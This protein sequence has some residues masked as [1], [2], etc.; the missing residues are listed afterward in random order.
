MKKIHRNFSNLIIIQLFLFHIIN[1]FYLLKKF[2]TTKINIKNNLIF[3]KH[4]LKNI[5]DN[6]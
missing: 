2:V 5:I 1:Y 4:Y 3:Q 6:R